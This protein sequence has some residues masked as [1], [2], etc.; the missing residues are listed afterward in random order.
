MDLRPLTL[1]ELLDRAFS[2]YRRHLWVFVGVMVPPALFAILVAVSLQVLNGTM[3]SQVGN[4]HPSP[5]QVFRTLVP[6][7][8]V[9]FIAGTLN[10]FV[11]AMAVGAMSVAVSQVYLGREATVK[12]GYAA[13]RDRAGRLTLVVVLVV[14][15]VFGLF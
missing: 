8:S 7:F 6:F 5:D 1:A 4:P 14:L 11:Y 9:A 2:I 10:I 3:M 15:R 12:L 13:V